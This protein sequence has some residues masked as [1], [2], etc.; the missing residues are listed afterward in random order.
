[1][2]RNKVD[3][4]DAVIFDMDGVIVDTESIWKRAEKETFSSVGVKIT[5]RLS[6]ITENLTTKEV[7]K[8]W[9]DRYPWQHKS[10][11]EV[12]NDVICMV[13][14]LIIKEGK[15]ICG[16]EELL[17]NLKNK[18]IKIALATNSPVRLIPI[19]LEK[20][21]LTD[22]FEVTCSAEDE[23]EG[24]PS[25]EV[26]ISAARKLNIPPENCLAIEDSFSGLL[27]AKK[28]GMKTVHFTRN[29]KQNF[30]QVADYCICNFS[31]FNF[32]LIN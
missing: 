3:K 25:P 9:F 8:F 31:E 1:M 13:E 19:I 18:N 12:E 29:H 10:L 17:N 22:Y 11:K 32:G 15:A 26:Y 5:D 20:L 7:T 30:N 24:K 4:I 28:A 21:A 2:N 14:Q 23:L 16:I 27:S 6:K